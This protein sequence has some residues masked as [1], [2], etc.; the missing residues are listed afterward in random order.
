VRNRINAV[1]TTEQRALEQKLHPPMG[2]G[3]DHPP[4]FHDGQ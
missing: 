4:P 2:P 1:L 3:P